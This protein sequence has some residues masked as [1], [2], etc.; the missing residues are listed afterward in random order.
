MNNPFE[1]LLFRVRVLLGLENADARRGGAAR[2][3][4]TTRGTLDFFW[5]GA[6]LVLAVLATQALLMAPRVEIRIGQA[7]RELQRELGQRE[8]LD[9]DRR[10]LEH[11]RSLL[12]A[13]HESDDA[14]RALGMQ[15]PTRG[16]T[17]RVRHD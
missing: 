1:Q 9:D 3:V 16:Q 12:G 17:Q 15:P 8:T 4:V 14:A 5:I 11:R 7:H 6:V 10:V 2:V 13:G